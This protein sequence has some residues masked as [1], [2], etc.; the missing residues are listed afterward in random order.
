MKEKREAL[1]WTDKLDTAVTCVRNADII[2]KKKRGR[3]DCCQRDENILKGGRRWDKK[4][5]KKLSERCSAQSFF[6]SFFFAVIRESDIWRPR[7]TGI[8][9]MEAWCQST[10]SVTMCLMESRALLVVKSAHM[11]AVVAAKEKKKKGTSS[12]QDSWQWLRWRPLTL[13]VTSLAGKS[14]TFSCPLL[15][16]TRGARRD[17]PQVDSSV[18]VWAELQ[19][20]GRTA[21]AS[22]RSPVVSVKWKKE[23]VLHSAGVFF[24]FSAFNPQVGTQSS[25]HHSG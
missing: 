9:E 5:E 7:S 24:F 11:S 17:W 13:V 6:F 20:H 21:E 8:S 25:D 16:A 14:V 1:H 18:K 22:P 4:Y 10:Q 15:A 23:Q 19:Q 2:I 12:A 3:G